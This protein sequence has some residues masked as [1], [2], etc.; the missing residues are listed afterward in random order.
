MI[1]T[2]ATYTALLLAATI[3]VTAIAA[4]AAEPPLIP[5]EALFGNPAKTQGRISPDGKYLSWLA[6][7]NGVLNVWVAPIGTPDQGAA[8]TKD[9]VRGIRTY[10]WSYD[11]RHLV[12]LQ[13]KGGNENYHVY[14]V[15]VVD[16]SERDLTPFDNVRA[17]L[18]RTSR[19]IRD[20]ILLTINKRD[21]KYPD[22]VRVN[23]ASGEMKVVAENPGFAGFIAGE[24]FEAPLAVKTLPSSAEELLRKKPD[25]TWE[26][27]IAFGADDARVSG[28]IGLNRA[29][30]ALLLRDSR[31]RD[32][33]ALKRIELKTG[34]EKLLAEDARTDIGGT[35]GDPETGEPVAYSINYDRPSWKALDP[36]YQA[37][38]DFLAKQDLGDWGVGSRTEDGNLWVIGA[39][40]D[41]KPGTTYLYDRTKKTLTKLFEARPA[42]ASAPL[43]R[44]HPVV[45]KSRDGL[46]LVS[47]LSLPKDSDTHS[48]GKPDK[49]LPLVMFVHGGP[50]ARDAFGYNSYHQW[51]A[52]RGYAVLSVNYRS[53]T[54]FGKSFVSAGD[55]QWMRAMQDDLN[56]AVAWAVKEKIADPAKVAIMGGSY[57]GYATL[58][59]V[60]R[61]PD[62]WACGVDIVGP[63]NL[64]T[65]LKSIPLYWEAGRA[66]FHKAMGNP[67]TEQGRAALKSSSPLYQADKIK[68]P[69]LVGQ[70]AN[71]PRVAKAE[72]DQM[73]AAMK[74]KSIPVTYVLYPDEGHGF[75]RPPNNISFNAVSEGFLKRCLG[76]RAEP[77]T[78]AS[79]KGSTIQVLEGSALI[80]G[81]DAALKAHVEAEPVPKKS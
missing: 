70:G 42:L 77:I 34:T 52:N 23:L 1:R 61:D 39:G 56:D 35:I 71:D 51:L 64:E 22:L 12:Y 67:D 66:Q 57:G 43:T 18:V 62:L 8:V 76:G 30:D 73:V 10:A 47:Y 6:P 27:W 44:M 60:T 13:D 63:S 19:K 59:G 28:P 79:L 58:A 31:G 78:S 37:D 49:P 11:G 26:T 32:T 46:N 50:W 29:G 68:K 7:V 21:P 69:L 5:R 80:E 53:S 48:A 20:E 24:D 41:V 14:S 17:D 3:G 72:S 16:K 33:G 25:G 9:A 45:L 65:L 15:D 54:G 55:M 4:S 40:S 2:A 81:L 38:L 74:A 75:A 36:H